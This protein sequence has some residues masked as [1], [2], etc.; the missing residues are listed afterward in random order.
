M[1]MIMLVQVNTIFMTDSLIEAN[2]LLNIVSLLNV[3][4]QD[5]P[6]NFPFSF[7]NKLGP[8]FGLL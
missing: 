3:Y 2:I 7:L 4:N 6:W 1:L 8:L 5:C